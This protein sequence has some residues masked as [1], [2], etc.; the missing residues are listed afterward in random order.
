[1]LCRTVNRALDFDRQLQIEVRRTPNWSR[2]LFFCSLCCCSVRSHRAPSLPPAFCRAAR[3]KLCVRGTHAGRSLLDLS[4]ISL[5]LLHQAT[6]PLI[7]MI[8]R[9]GAYT[10]PVRIEYNMHF[11]SS[12]FRTANDLA[13]FSAAIRKCCSIVLALRRS[14]WSRSNSQRQDRRGNARSGSHFLCYRSSLFHSGCYEKMDH[15]KFP[16]KHGT[17]QLNVHENI[18]IRAYPPEL[19]RLRWI[20][21]S[22]LISQTHDEK[23]E[24]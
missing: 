19:Q 18:T 10:M 1:M 2:S 17:A 22:S 3:K 20:S 13:R 21:L 12:H 23:R 5:L 14:I 16:N 7:N 9:L 8:S 15:T 11:I 4:S 6:I 24:R